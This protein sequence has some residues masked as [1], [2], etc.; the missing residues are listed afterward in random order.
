MRTTSIEYRIELQGRVFRILSY[1]TIK[2]PLPG[3]QTFLVELIPGTR[4]VEWKTLVSNLT[5]VTSQDD[6]ETLLR[7]YLNTLK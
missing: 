7:V 1:I 3:H 4:G 6:A 5:P 2:P